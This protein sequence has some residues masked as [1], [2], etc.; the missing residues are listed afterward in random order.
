MII[1]YVISKKKDGVLLFIHIEPSDNRLESVTWNE[2]V[3]ISSS[4]HRIADARTVQ[5]KLVGVAKGLGFDLDLNIV[6]VQ[7]VNA[8]IGIIDE[9]TL[10]ML[11]A[12]QETDEDGG[13]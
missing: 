6:R 9:S 1:I 4:F 8:I 3:D 2:N 13:E 12:P 7:Q 11:D 5:K 10:E